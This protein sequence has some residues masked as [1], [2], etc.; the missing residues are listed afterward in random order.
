[1]KSWKPEFQ[2]QG[3]WYDNA[4]RFATKEEAERSAQRRFAVWTMP[5][6]WRASESPDPVNYRNTADSADE[7][8]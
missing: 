7:S 3:A 1:M 5:S 8:V 4:Q 6:D 2:V